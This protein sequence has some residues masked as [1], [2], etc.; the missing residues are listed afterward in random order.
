VPGSRPPLL[1]SSSRSSASQ[2]TTPPAALNCRYDIASTGTG[3]SSIRACFA[4]LRANFKYMVVNYIRIGSSYAYK[5]SSILSGIFFNA[6][7]PCGLPLAQFAEFASHI[8]TV[9][10]TQPLYSITRLCD[11]IP[12]EFGN[13]T[14]TTTEIYAT[15]DQTASWNEFFLPALASAIKAKPELLPYLYPCQIPARDCRVLWSSFARNTQTWVTQF[16]AGTLPAAPVCNTDENIPGHCTIRGGQVQLLY[17]P[18]VTTSSRDICATTTFNPFATTAL[19]A[20][21]ILL[22]TLRLPSLLTL[23]HSGRWCRLCDIPWSYT[24]CQ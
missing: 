12:R 10:V 4:R 19:P 14:T 23:C 16:Q 18:P 8:V 7:N 17:F 15:L 21:G 1:P 13:A 5:C 2:V 9:Q 11:G 20:N 24:L 22:H 6:S 3:T